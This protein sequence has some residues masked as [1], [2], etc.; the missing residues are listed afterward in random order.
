MQ[1]NLQEQLIH[2]SGLVWKW[3]RCSLSEELNAEVPN[4]GCL[5]EV[6]C[7]LP[8]ERSMALLLWPGLD[9]QPSTC[10]ISQMRASFHLL[11]G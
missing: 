2:S 6:L 3:W 4:E 7:F 11:H 9:S 8:Q 5:S 10:L 1:Q